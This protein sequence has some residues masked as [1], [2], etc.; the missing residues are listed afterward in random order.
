MRLCACYAHMLLMTGSKQAGCKLPAGIQVVLFDLK[1]QSCDDSPTLYPAPNARP[2]TNVF[3]KGDER[4]SPD[5]SLCSLSS[6]LRSVS[7]IKA[8]SLCQ[9]ELLASLLSLYTLVQSGL[10][11]A[12]QPPTHLTA[13]KLSQLCPHKVTNWEL[14]HSFI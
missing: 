14:A 13:G 4:W 3:L 5:S 1:H 2:G 6:H 12:P 11:T 9:D 10:P 8:S 7:S